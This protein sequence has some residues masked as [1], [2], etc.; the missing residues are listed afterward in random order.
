MMTR[1]TPRLLS[2]F[3]MSGLLLLLGALP[4][5][6]HLAAGDT[7][8]AV[9]AQASRQGHAEAFDLDEALRA[10]PV[11]LY[12]FPAAYTRGCNIQA[13]EFSLQTEA[14]AAAGARVVGVSL[15]S[16][17]RLH[18]F[19]ADPDFCA[20]RFPIVSDADEH[21]ARAFALQIRAAEA[22]RTNLRGHALDH[23]LAERA[24]FV[25]GPGRRIVA[26]IGGLAPAENVAEA[27]R[28]VQALQA[29]SRR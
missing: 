7:A 8:P 19:S 4:A 10:G 2:Q 3:A 11:V 14:F 16:L 27:L 9:H 18:E 22:G 15:D 13:H 25:I 5:W 20:G 26:A 12:F 6:A 28:T 1:S 17:A 23:G 24:S 21:I 29:G